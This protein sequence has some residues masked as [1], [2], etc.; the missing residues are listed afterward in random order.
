MNV[1]ELKEILNGLPDDATVIV[2]EKF[3]RGGG[4]QDYLLGKLSTDGTRVNG[5]HSGTIDYYNKNIENAE[6][7]LQAVYAGRYHWEKAKTENDCDVMYHNDDGSFLMQTWA[8]ESDK[9]TQLKIINYWSKRKKEEQEELKK[10]LDKRDKMVINAIE[11]SCA[12]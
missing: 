3:G 1:K 10:L 6:K 8:G 11:L 9:W 2:S 12:F 7:I 4:I 5:V